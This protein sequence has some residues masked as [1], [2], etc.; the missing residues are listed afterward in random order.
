MT[1]VQSPLF[2]ELVREGA[3]SVPSVI[4]KE[5]LLEV[6]A[7]LRGEGYECEEPF[8]FS[9]IW[10]LFTKRE[11]ATYFALNIP[12]F[13]LEPDENLFG[14]VVADIIDYIRT[15]NLENICIKICSNPKLVEYIDQI[16]MC[17]DGLI[18]GE[19][20]KMNSYEWFDMLNYHQLIWWIQYFINLEDG[21]KITPEMSPESIEKANALA[22]DLELLRRTDRCLIYNN[23]S[24]FTVKFE[25]ADEVHF[26]PIYADIPGRP[27][28]PVFVCV[29]NY[30]QTKYSDF[31]TK[32]GSS[33][34]RNPTEYCEIQLSGKFFGC[35]DLYKVVLSMYSIKL[36]TETINGIYGCLAS[37]DYDRFFYCG[38]AHFA[39][40]DLM[41]VC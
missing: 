14:L 31:F 17:I 32:L 26:S 8:Y 4:T 1:S 25:N 27:E 3:I 15:R 10:T 40:F 9:I 22:A 34:P 41:G 38:D 13:K 19:M 11:L 2:S 5:W 6:F 12:D 20:A 24:D 21:S 33:D 16:I 37:Y 7:K 36:S 23:L 29:K 39:V 35:F 30:D 28:P 18:N